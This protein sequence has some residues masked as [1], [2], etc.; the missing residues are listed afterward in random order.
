MAHHK[1]L[2][3]SKTMIKVINATKKLKSLLR[4]LKEG[5]YGQFPF[6][7]TSVS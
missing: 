7:N 1:V 5:P 4:S 3:S 6:M 2:S